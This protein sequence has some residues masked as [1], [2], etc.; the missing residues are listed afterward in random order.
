MRKSSV[1]P[2]ASRLATLP[3]S[4][5]QQRQQ[6]I[7]RQ[8]LLRRRDVTPPAVQ[9][10]Q[11][12]QAPRLLVQETP[13]KNL[14]H[15]RIVVS[16]RALTANDKLPVTSFDK[17]LPVRHHHRCVRVCG[18]QVA[19]VVDLDALQRHFQ[20]QQLFQRCPVIGKTPLLCLTA[21]QGFFSV[22]SNGCEKSETLVSGRKNSHPTFV[23]M[24]KRT[25][26]PRSLV[27]GRRGVDHRR[28]RVR[29]VKLR[30]ERSHDFCCR[31]L[32]RMMRKKSAVAAMT[33]VAKTKHFDTALPLVQPQRQHIRLFPVRQNVARACLNHRQRRQTIAQ[34]RGT[35]VLL[36]S[37]RFRH[38]SFQPRAHAF[39]LA[40][41]KRLRPGDQL[42]VALRVR[43][44]HARGRATFDMI[45]QA[46]TRTMRKDRI[47]ARAQQEN[48]LQ[49]D[50]RRI[51]RSAGNKRSEIASL[52][53]LLAAMLHDLR[54]GM[55]AAQ[56]DRREALVVAQ[57]NVVT[58]LQRLDQRRFRQQ[59]FRFRLRH[60]QLETTRRRQH[61]LQA[62]RQPF[63]T[64]V[65]LK[66]FLQIARLADI[67]GSS[68]SVQHAIATRTR[69]RLQMCRNDDRKSLVE[70]HTSTQTQE[71][72]DGEEDGKGDIADDGRRQWLW[73]A[74]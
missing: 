47:A 65:G 17:P 26:K 29:G 14:A 6:G 32:A 2:L 35:F 8:H 15:H 24:R 61:A 27:R 53:A 5:R 1:H 44:A 34:R 52:H 69:G 37:A 28:R 45:L 41:Q 16:A 42:R 12:G 66:T 30:D 7:I 46:R 54:K 40:F 13:R 49:L 72:E 68:L 48:F 74:S 73:A 50:D 10:H 3:L 55:V 56:Q 20:F 60:Q 38:L 39:R 63:G 33:T 36:R 18:T 4:N 70:H 64:R 22:R 57:K 11:G 21:T 58:R 67:Q 59:G 19:V 31:N 71:D 62:I 9:H 51:D 43:V 25:L 23:A